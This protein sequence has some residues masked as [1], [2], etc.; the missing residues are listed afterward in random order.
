M[1]CCTK[2][3]GSAC[4]IIIIMIILL[5]DIG[6]RTCF[7]VMVIT[8]HQTRHGF[9]DRKANSKNKYKYKVRIQIQIQIQTTNTYK[10]KFLQPIGKAK[11]H[12]T[13]RGV[14][15]PKAGLYFTSACWLKRRLSGAS[16]LPT[17]SS[18]G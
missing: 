15:D 11:L 8:L 13:R 1:I 17:E 18:K 5:Q 14:K 10:N 9:K 16:R 2:I 12:Q 7:P 4:L 3:S 6:S